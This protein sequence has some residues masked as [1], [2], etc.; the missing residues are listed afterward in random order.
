MGLLRELR[1]Y[2]QWLS[3]KIILHS[4]LSVNMCLQNHLLHISLNSLYP[5]R[6]WRM[7]ATFEVL[8]SFPLFLLV[9][10]L[11]NFAHIETDVAGSFVSYLQYSTIRFLWI[12]SSWILSLRRSCKTMSA[13]ASLLHQHM[14]PY[15]ANNSHLIEF[16]LLP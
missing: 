13:Y 11:V 3:T 15:N 16:F 9:H 5:I 8:I 10:L 14:G 12:S 1:K 2:L 4:L 6:I 7:S